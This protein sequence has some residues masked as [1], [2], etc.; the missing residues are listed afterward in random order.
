MAL[1]VAGYVMGQD[2]GFFL[3]DWE[4]RNAE[5]PAHIVKDKPEGE[6]S[7]QIFVDGDQVVSKVP[8]YIYGNNAVTWGGNLNGHATVMKDINNL[9]PNVLRWPGGNSSNGYFWNL[10]PGER[11]EDIPADISPGY[12]MNPASWRMS[13]PQYYQLLESTESAGIV[14]VNYSYARYGTGPNPVATAAH[15]AAEWVRYDN[16]RSKFWE[17]GNE[18]FGNWQAGY[19]IDVSLNQDGQPKFIN[20]QLYGQHCKVFIDSMRSAA[21]EIGVEIKIGV[22]AYDSETSYD[23]ISEVWN[24]GMMPEVGD[25][26]DFLIVHS[27]FT[28]HN[29]DSPAS[30]IL[31]SHDVPSHVM[32]DIVADMEEAGKAMI[33]VAFTEWNLFAVRSMQQV[34]FINGMHTAL[35]LG[36]FVLNDYGLATRW[37]L[38]NSWADGDDHGMF[39][40]GGEP[41]V[42][43]YNPRPD[44]YYMYYFQKYFGDRMVS[45][46][47]SGSDQVICYASTFSSGETGLVIINKGTSGEMAEISLEN[48]DL[49][50]WYYTMTLTGGDDN[51]EFS[52]K[53][54]LNGKG[55]DEE[56]GGPDDYESVKA[57]A[58]STRG[59]IKVAVPPL[60]VVYVM[61]EK[62]GPF[63]Y[64]SSRVESDSMVINL[65]LSEDVQDVT[66]PTDFSFFLADGT[67][68]LVIGV[69]RDTQALYQ[70]NLTLDRAVQNSDTMFLFY[71][72]TGI[73]SMK[74]NMLEPFTNEKV[75]NSLPGDPFKV[76]FQ[77]NCSFSGVVLQGCRVWFN[78]EEGLSD[79][80]GRAAFHALEGD[81]LVSVEKEHLETAAD[82]ALSVSSDTLFSLSLDSSSYEVVIHI[83]DTQTGSPL[84][85]V[86]V[87]CPSQEENKSKEGIVS[88][89]LFAGS[90]SFGLDYFNYS[91]ELTSVEIESDTLLKVEMSRSH[92]QVKFRLRNGVTPVNKATVGLNGET[93]ISD[94]LGR[95][96]F[97]SVPVSATMDYI[98]QRENYAPIEG[99]VEVVTDTT[100]ELQMEKTLTGVEGAIGESSLKVYPNPALDR[101]FIEGGDG[102]IVDLEIVD[103]SGKRMLHLPL[104][105]ATHT[106]ELPLHLAPGV[107]L[108][109]VRTVRTSYVERIVVNAL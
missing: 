40:R 59:G 47:V 77:V 7:V 82:M 6:T 33:P 25:V 16:G 91:P 62:P 20:G 3:D 23:P 51:G 94:Q 35:V 14:C 38:T 34:S 9:S 48:I 13:T 10:S 109:K 86:I 41:G 76:V 28:P 36:E 79:E 75:E 22:V 72:G 81:C 70:L 43:L 29:Q 89:A 65:E 32:G 80:E 39:S 57:Y 83:T 19:E 71:S 74:E 15:M 88:F 68:I 54:Y 64:I 2:P 46:S 30:T 90:T 100:I 108:L 42:D 44:F 101:I 8:T 1:M 53:V 107:Y 24:E 104:E 31:N 12:G 78:G 17:L 45:S 66:D 50:S 98:V 5:V 95:S 102:A 37:D 49:G 67:E 56:G 84:S 99:S 103:L 85:G 52:R 4:E 18:N 27:Y 26:A 96:I 61:A 58:S 60:S 63:S 93:L 106:L 55:T 73:L 11:P 97:P 69:E 87:S 105:T 21:A 92:A